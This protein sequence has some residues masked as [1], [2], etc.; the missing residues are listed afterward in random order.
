M[1]GSL[2]LLEDQIAEI[3]IVCDQDPVVRRGHR[4]NV[5]IG[6]NVD[7]SAYSNDIMTEHA[8]P[9]GRCFRHAL[10]NQE[11]HL[12]PLKGCGYRPA[13]MFPLMKP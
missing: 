1:R 5:R 11:A 9:D 6:G 10:I 2:L 3:P 8:Q 13:A 7:I 4:W 12:M